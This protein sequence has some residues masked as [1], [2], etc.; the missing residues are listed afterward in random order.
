MKENIEKKI[1]EGIEKAVGMV[2][3]EREK[4]YTNNL[5]PTKD[6]IQ[7]MVSNY[8]NTNAVIS[9]GTGLIPGPLGMA[10]S[11]PEI[12]LIIRN[13]LTMVYDI[14]KANGHKKITR[15]LM[16]GVFIS[17]MGN[18]TGNLLII[19]GQR[20]VVKRVGMQA[21][22]KI[23]AILGGKITQ[24]AAKSMAA[25]W[26]PVAGAAAM[27]AWSKY[28]TNK[29]GT[30]AV[31]IFSKEIVME[32][33]EI[34]EID[35]PFSTVVETNCDEFAIEKLKIRIIINLIKIDGK[36]DDREIELL[37]ELMD[38]F[39]LES[40]DK[41]ELISEINSK[42]KISIDYNL[43]KGNSEEILYLLID[44]VAIA[45]ADGEV[46]ITEKLFIKEVAKSLD[47]DQN[48]LNLL[49]ES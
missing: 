41:L 6:M 36:I 46:H 2:I 22:Q 14:A 35:L 45:K 34:K 25:K 37:E 3:D 10:A 17:A 42:N 8:S 19:Q 29:I 16:L 20:I 11:V 5:A 18:A 30:K 31:E 9:G 26:L 13:Q 43:L 12:I 33:N 39:Q 23:I 40:N 48:D 47:F 44:L 15:E 7:K 49:F 28:S 32:D 27:A 24:Q 38:K 1:T 21:M 4:Y